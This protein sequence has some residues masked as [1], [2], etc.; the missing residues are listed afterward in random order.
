M[1]IPKALSLFVVL[2]IASSTAYLGIVQ[3]SLTMKYLGAAAEIV[4]FILCI[5]VLYARRG[6]IRWKAAIPILTIFCW[7][8][9]RIVYESLLSLNVGTIVNGLV[10]GSAHYQLPFIALAIVSIMRLRGDSLEFLLA[11]YAKLA[12]PLSVLLLYYSIYLLDLE[13]GI[14]YLVFGNLLVPCSLLVF[15][16][17]NSKHYIVG[18]F[19]ILLLLL[20]ASVLG[21]RSFA[22][23]ALYITLFSVL[24]SN[25]L[26]YRQTVVLFCLLIVGFLVATFFG[27]G[28]RSIVSHEEFR[29]VEKFRFDSL[30]DSIAK[31]VTELDLSYLYYWEGNSRA[32]ILKEAFSGFSMSNWLFG[33]GFFAEYSSVH[34]YRSTIEIGWAQEVFRWGLIYTLVTIF[35]LLVKR[36]RLL[37]GYRYLGV[38]RQEA[39]ALATVSLVKILDGFIFG[40]ARYDTY[41]LLVFMALMITVLKPL[42]AERAISALSPR[43]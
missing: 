8:L 34:G 32:L 25:S 16:T 19:S 15:F 26:K 7:P 10:L 38:S 3:Q 30:T 5:L 33:R 20:T 43:R 35:V 17:S 24:S 11:A 21:S 42:S 23:V 6:A 27:D 41:N 9:L 36:L 1:R 28:V 40:L 29:V 4:V 37:R 2:S 13:F 39:V 12:L 22:L 14:A 31:S 18:W